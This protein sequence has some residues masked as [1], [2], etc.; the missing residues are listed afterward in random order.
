MYANKKDM[1]IDSKS[2]YRVSFRPLFKWR[3][4]LNEC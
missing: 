2:N 3:D 1:K 4:K